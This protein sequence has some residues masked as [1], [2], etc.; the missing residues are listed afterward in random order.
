MNWALRQVGFLLLEAV[1][2]LS[3]QAQAPVAPAQLVGRVVRADT[4]APIE[5]AIVS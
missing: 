5:G 4:G 1:L 3:I 2:A